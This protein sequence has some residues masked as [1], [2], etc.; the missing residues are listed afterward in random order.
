MMT[1]ANKKIVAETYFHD[2]PGGRGIFFRATCSFPELIA[3][4]LNKVIKLLSFLEHSR[5]IFPSLN[6]NRHRQ[7]DYRLILLLLVF[8]C[9]FVI[10]IIGQGHLNRD[11]LT[12]I[13]TRDLPT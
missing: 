8:I 4:P 2:P 3:G 5:L 10:K 7:L 13:V 6:Q 9:L 12:K 11:F 1:F